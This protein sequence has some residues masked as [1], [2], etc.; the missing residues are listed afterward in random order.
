MLGAAS[1]SPNIMC[2]AKM[3]PKKGH[4]LVF[5]REKEA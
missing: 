5:K 2:M 3:T 4:D 1:S